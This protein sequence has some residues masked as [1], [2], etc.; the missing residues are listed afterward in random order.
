VRFRGAKTLMR[1]IIVILEKATK[2]CGENG[3]WFRNPQ[4]NRVW[5]NY[6]LCNAKVMTWE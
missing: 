1:I 4:S 6:T 5:T 3:Q 2:D